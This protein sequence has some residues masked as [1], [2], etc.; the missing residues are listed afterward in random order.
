MISSVGELGTGALSRTDGIADAARAKARLSTP[1][2]TIPQYIGV[3]TG[4]THDSQQTERPS[5]L[6][7][8][9]DMLGFIASPHENWCFGSP[10]LTSQ[11]HPEPAVFTQV[12]PRRNEAGEQIA[13]SSPTPYASMIWALVEAQQLPKARALL[14]L[15]PDLPEF[16]KLKKLLSAPV[17]TASHRKDFDRE[18]EYRWLAK[19]A[20]N[21]IGKWVAISGDSL[22]EAADTLKDLRERVKKTAPARSPLLHYVE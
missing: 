13:G 18:P 10:V 1:T 19:N 16:I 21:Y 7:V 20:K 5:Q 14:Q 11:V 6:G 8:T 12:R 2:S 4:W 9:R 22:I 15:V 3:G 17:A